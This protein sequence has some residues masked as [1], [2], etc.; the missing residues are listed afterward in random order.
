MKR[1]FCMDL[2][3]KKRGRK[4]KLINPLAKEVARLERENKKALQE[5]TTSWN[6]HWCSKK[7]SA[8]LGI[9]QKSN[10]EKSWYLL[11]FL[12]YNTVH[13]HSGIGLMTPEQIHYGQAQQILQQ[14]T[15][16]LE[17]AFKDHAKRFKGKPPKP[18]PLP[19]AAW[20]NKPDESQAVFL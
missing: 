6:H 1:L 11:L 17:S 18:F 13:K 5:V 15:K 19:K 8:I 2:P 10:G 3:R 9:S 7:I 14:R 16:V 20:T 12:W 4:P